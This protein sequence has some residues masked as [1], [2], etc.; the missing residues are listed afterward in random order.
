MSENLERGRAMRR[1]LMGQRSDEAMAKGAAAE[2]APTLNRIT[3][4]VL[5]GQIWLDP[6]LEV[7]QRSLITIAALVALGKEAQLKSHILGGLRVGLRQ[8]QIAGVILHLAF[9]VGW[10][11]AYGALEV[12][13]RAF[14]EAAETTKEGKG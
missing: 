3:D 8:E 2:L 13:R 11:A 9:Y 6:A 14:A 10:P 7:P 5:F 4:E 12:A 1:R